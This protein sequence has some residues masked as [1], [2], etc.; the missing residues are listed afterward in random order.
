LDTF[1]ELGRHDDSVLNML[2]FLFTKT[3]TFVLLAVAAVS[4]VML[5]L[6]AIRGLRTKRTVG[7]VNA[8]L[9]ELGAGKFDVEVKQTARGEL[10][11]LVRAFNETTHTLSESRERLNSYQRSLEERVDERTR[12]LNSATARVLQVSQT[13]ALTG[14]PNRVLLLRRLDEA[15]KRAAKDTTRV[16]VLF[17]DLDFFKTVNDSHGH[18]AGDALLR[19]VAE[20]LKAEMRPEDLV[21]RFGGDEFIVMLTRLDFQGADAVATEIA[22]RVLVS[23]S[24]PYVIAGERVNANASIGM[25]T[26]PSDA[27]TAADLVKHADLAMYSA[28]QGGRNQISR[29]A[30]GTGHKVADRGKLEADIRRG[31]AAGEFFL[32]FQP[33]VEIGSGAPVGLEALMRWR[34]PTR[35]LVSPAE[36]IPIAEQTGLIHELGRRALE[37][38]C[39]QFKYWQQRDIFPRV[40]VNVSA[41][42]LEDSRWLE[43]VREII[44]STGMP[45]RYLDLEIT[46][47]MLVSDPDRIVAMLGEVNRMGVTLTLDDFG[48]GYSSLSYLTRLPFHTI[49]IDRSFIKEI[50][51]PRERGIVQAIIAV[52]HSLNMRVIAEGIES[53]LQLGILRELGAEEAQG[54]YMSKPLEVDAIEPWWS[55]QLAAVGSSLKGHDPA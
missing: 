39:A 1:N 53:P 12:E 4:L 18:E 2:D 50:E 43:S 7:A 26:Y 37:M 54:F 29:F 44:E 24:N 48:T 51:L 31:I 5:A 3:G 17:I 25:A 11:E 9:R 45:A 36:F 47:S 52:A 10:G 46:E 19:S 49:K 15:L 41:K 27:R 8:A 14:L 6:I 30:E 21:A 42:Q 33:Q 32:V 34:H 28:K 38:T 16:V 35:G 55:T 23:L 22:G 40:S 13:D 20:R